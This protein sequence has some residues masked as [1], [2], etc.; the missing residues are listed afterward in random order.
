MPARPGI[1][2]VARGR[3]AGYSGAVSR[4]LPHAVQGSD[5]W[6]LLE[7]ASATFLAAAQRNMPAVRKAIGAKKLDPKL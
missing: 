6:H 3:N 1:E 2:V 5:L 4:A 7:N